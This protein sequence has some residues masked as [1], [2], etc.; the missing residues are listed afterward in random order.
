MSVDLSLRPSE[1]TQANSHQECLN[2]APRLRVLNLL[3]QPYDRFSEWATTNTRGH[4]AFAKYRQQEIAAKLFEDAPNLEAVVLGPPI[5]KE[6][7]REPVLER[8]FFMR[9]ELTDSY[10]HYRSAAIVVDKGEL[11]GYIPGTGILD[12]VPEDPIFQ[13]Y[14]YKRW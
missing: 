11:Q 14:G 4:K 10:G 8:R 12:V 7:E 3:E 5:S 1:T 6:T 13:R 2:K 9:G